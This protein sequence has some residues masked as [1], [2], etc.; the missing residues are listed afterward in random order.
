MFVTVCLA[1][2]NKT[3]KRD[4]NL[5]ILDARA[6]SAFHLILKVMERLNVFLEHDRCRFSPPRDS[7]Q[8]FVFP[9][10]VRY[11]SAPIVNYYFLTGIQ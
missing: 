5:T 3:G 11:F 1:C 8:H 7:S 4:V 10:V 6:V 2:V 9:G